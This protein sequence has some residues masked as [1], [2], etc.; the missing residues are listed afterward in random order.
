M[1]MQGATNPLARL[2]GA[3][4]NH[5]RASECQSHLPGRAS[6]YSARLGNHNFK[7]MGEKVICIFDCQKPETKLYLNQLKLP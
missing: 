7:H 1:Y 3:S 5:G 4:K 2:P 6:C